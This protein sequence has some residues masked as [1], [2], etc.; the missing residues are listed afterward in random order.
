[1]KIAKFL[2]IIA[3]LAVASC[4]AVKRT[5]HKT[6][7]EQSS[8]VAKG[9]DTSSKVKVETHKT[10]DQEATTGSQLKE[11]VHKELTVD[12]IGPLNS[13]V[14]ANDYVDTTIGGTRISANGPLSSITLSPSGAIT[15]QGK[16][17]SATYKETGSREKRD[18]ATAKASTEENTATVTENRG[19][20]T[21]KA[22]SVTK[23]TDTDTKKVKIGSPAAIWVPVLFGGLI[24]L[25][26]AWRFGWL[27]K[28]R[29]ADDKDDNSLSKMTY[30][31][32]PPPPAE[33][34]P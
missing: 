1:M 23:I 14:N 7:I 28:K 34:K 25:Y 26:L 24:L 31:P 21:T 27:R 18:T 5:Q 16:V 8:Q 19:I 22:E 10:T 17:K 30:S 32:P 2:L 29:K 9:I 12:F 4:S 6:E 3:A 15:I 33:K 20:D 13:G 11:Q